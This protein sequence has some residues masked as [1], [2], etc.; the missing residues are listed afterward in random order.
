[1]S[2]DQTIQLNATA[3]ARYYLI[4]I[5]KLAPTP[6]TGGYQVELDEVSLNS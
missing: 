2:T 3:S 5:T 1:M 6:V 4:W